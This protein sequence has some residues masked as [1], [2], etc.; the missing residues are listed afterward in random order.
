M[1][2]LRNDQLLMSTLLKMIKI[3]IP[4]VRICG[5]IQSNG[6]QSFEIHGSLDKF[7]LGSRAT[8][9]KYVSIRL[10]SND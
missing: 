7:C 10:L 5:T 8:T 2:K 9:K 3:R 6:S 1:I 4:I